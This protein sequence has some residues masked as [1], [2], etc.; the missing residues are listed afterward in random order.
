MLTGNQPAGD[1]A[2]TTVA[3]G[4]TAAVEYDGKVWR[5]LNEALVLTFDTHAVRF[6][7]GP[8][9]ASADELLPFS[10]FDLA[11]E[12]DRLQGVAPVV[13]RC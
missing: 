13:M 7:I 11:I 1:G 6:A 9:N 10:P 5:L 12:S 8:R 4:R 2:A 3:T